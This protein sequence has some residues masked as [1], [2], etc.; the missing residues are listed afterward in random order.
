MDRP[1]RARTIVSCLVGACIGLAVPLTQHLQIKGPMAGLLFWLW[2]VG[3]VIAGAILQRR[4]FI[5]YLAPVTAWYGILLLAMV[6]GWM[7]PTSAKNA[8]DFDPTAAVVYLIGA[9]PF[10]VTLAAVASFI[11]GNMASR[12]RF[13]PGG[14]GS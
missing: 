8:S 7:A 14:R 4:A 9:L 6:S 5:P 1:S 10:V 3:P 2:F 13:L 11:A 12:L